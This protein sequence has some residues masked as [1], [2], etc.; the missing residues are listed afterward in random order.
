MEH[1]NCGAYKAFL[2]D[3]LGN[4]EK[5]GYV[6]EFAHHKKYAKRLTEFLTT[7]LFD[8]KKENQDQSISKYKDAIQVHS[9]IMDLRGDVELLYTT[10]PIPEF[11]E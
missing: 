4:Y 6:I 3:D 8:R 10:A 11:E 7:Y 5:H 2:K 9:F 1:R